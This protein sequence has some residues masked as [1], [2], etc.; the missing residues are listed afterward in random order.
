MRTVAVLKGKNMWNPDPRIVGA[1]PLRFSEFIDANGLVCFQPQTIFSFR[2]E[3]NAQI[4]RVSN[5]VWLQIH[6]TELPVL[7]RVLTADE[8]LV[9]FATV[10]V[11]QRLRLHEAGRL[12]STR[13]MSAELELRLFDKVEPPKSISNFAARIFG[14][15]TERRDRQIKRLSLEVKTNDMYLVRRKLPI[16]HWRG[17]LFIPI[18]GF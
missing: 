4:I 10:E 15:I 18:D 3:R 9:A 14:P 6:G 17:K 11:D 13:V 5:E 2:E 8:L 1:D 12:E 16:G 7:D